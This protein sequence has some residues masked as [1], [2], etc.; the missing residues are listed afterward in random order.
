MKRSLAEVESIVRNRICRVCTDQDITG[1]CGLDDPERCA[2]FRLFPLVA[3]AIDSTSSND[4]RDYVRA[5]RKHVCSVCM[6]QAEDGTCETRK[7]VN[8]A[9]DAYL[10]LVVEAIEEAT[11]RQFVRLG[12]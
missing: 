4:I 1:N 7:L 11:G 6:D 5:I 12:C 3:R 8:C 9:L 2:L 10:P